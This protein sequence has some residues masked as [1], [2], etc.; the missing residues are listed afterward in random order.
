MLTK[1]I[2]IIA[3]T[4]GKIYVFIFLSVILVTSLFSSIIFVSTA[5]DD[6]KDRRVIIDPGHGGIDGGTND[7]ATFFEK[8]INLQ[9]AQ[10]LKK[11]LLSDNIEADLTRESDVSLDNLNNASPSRH[12]R[13]LIA[14]VTQFNSGKYDFFVSI[15]VNYSSNPEA[16]GPL[17]LYS[18]G[19]P[20]A[21]KLAKCIQYRLNHHMKEYLG[22]ETNSEPQEANLFIFRYSNTPGVLVETG[23]IS[24][25]EDKA[26]LQTEAYQ[27]K[28]A[29][30]IYYGIKDYYSK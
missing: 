30:A 25:Q 17:V 6:L 27:L 22:K 15:H 19:I 29:E 14:R 13:D 8:D 11:I 20:Q 5:G 1:K 2:H 10:K 3:F 23:F 12:E 9:I 24:N 18:P 7:N 28:I 26:L 21:N 16:R 4:K